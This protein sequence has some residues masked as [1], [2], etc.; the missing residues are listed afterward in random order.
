MS[1]SLSVNRPVDVSDNRAGHDFAL[2]CAVGTP[3]RRRI[4]LVQSDPR[5][6]RDCVAHI[7]AIRPSWDTRTVAIEEEPPRLVGAPGFDDVLVQWGGTNA[8]ARLPDFVSKFKAIPRRAVVARAF[9]AE[10]M[11]EAQSLGIW[12][13]GRPVAL[14]HV[15]ALLDAMVLRERRERRPLAALCSLLDLSPRQNQVLLGLL[16]GASR[17]EVA[18]S[19]GCST[20]TVH[21][22][23]KRICEKVRLAKYGTAHD[24]RSPRTWDE[25]LLEIVA[26]LRS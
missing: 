4:L 14:D 17:A 13:L 26:W 10:E 9:S 24:V 2:T 8:F 16:E 23:T 19:L 21:Q 1:A 12:L 20:N 11:L 7:A 25:L 6:G 15:V 22:H 18:A 5:W 3:R